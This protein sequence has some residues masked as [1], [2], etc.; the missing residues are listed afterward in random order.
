MRPHRGRHV[1]AGVVFLLMSFG[2]RVAGQPQPPAGRALTKSGVPLRGQELFALDLGN[3]LMGEVPAALKLLSGNVEVVRKDGVPM[4]KAATAS[5]FLITLPEVLPA[6]FTLEFDLIPKVG[7]PPPDLSVEGTPTINQGPGS[8]HLLWQADAYLAVIGGAQDNYEQPMP[9]DLR[10]SMPGVLTHVGL[11]FEGN[12]VRLYTNG[13]RLYTL[14]R[15]FARGRVLRVSM[16]GID[17]GVGAVYLAGLRIATGGPVIA[18]NPTPAPGTTKVETPPGTGGRIGPGPPGATERQQSGL[19]GSETVQQ[20]SGLTGE[21]TTLPA[22]TGI[23]PRVSAQGDASLSWAALQEATSYFVVRWKVDDPACCSNFSPPAGV[24]A[25]TWQDGVLPRSGTYGYRVYATSSAGISV[26]ETRVMYQRIA[27]VSEPAPEPAPSPAPAG[28]AS[29]QTVTKTLS[30]VP[31]S[32]T[33][34]PTGITATG[35]FSA[36][37]SRTIDL[38]E[39]LATGG[40]SVMAPRTIVVAGITAVGSVRSLAKSGTSGG[41]G[42]PASRTIDM[43]ALTGAGG[44]GAVPSR[45]ITLPGL[46]AT[47]GFA[48]IPPRTITLPGLTAT[49]SGTT[50]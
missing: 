22:V 46:T 26:G 17:E 3:T 10:T 15:Q 20:K 4:L 33:I 36:I 30:P 28:P 7:G 47:G 42:I 31:A 1:W 34:T 9:E 8:A 5:A 24:P 37:A 38:A 16:G 32:R 14:E 13:H 11:S 48:L 12:T 49:G 21:T 18:A 45:T 29:K 50:P 25:L 19:T 23:T 6:D 35:A 39:I 40:F 27:S 2:G 44:F 43:V 41:S